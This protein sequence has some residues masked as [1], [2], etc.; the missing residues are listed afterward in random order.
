MVLTFV[1]CLSFGSLWWTPLSWTLN[2]QG[3]NIK[4]KL[5]SQYFIIFEPFFGQKTLKNNKGY[6]FVLNKKF[7]FSFL[8]VQSN[9]KIFRVK[10][11]TKWFSV[12]WKFCTK[13]YWAYEL[14]S[15]IVRDVICFNSEISPYILKIIQNI[16]STKKL[17]ENLKKKKNFFRSSET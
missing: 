9:V 8:A 4:L 17:F 5:C 11:T 6:F 12:T 10:L 16:A 3:K 2:C 1:F 7:V 13:K 14:N 15:S